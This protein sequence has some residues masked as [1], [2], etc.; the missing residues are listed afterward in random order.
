MFKEKIL[1]QVSIILQSVESIVSQ[2]STYS[3]SENCQCQENFWWDD[4]QEAV[5]NFEFDRVSEI[6]FSTKSETEV[7][8]S[9]FLTAPLVP[10]YTE[11]TSPYMESALVAAISH[12][13]EDTAMPL[14]VSPVPVPGPVTEEEED[15]S[16]AERVSRR[17]RHA[18]QLED[19]HH[20]LAS[21]D[22]VTTAAANVSPSVS[23]SSSCRDEESNNNII[24]DN[25]NITTTGAMCKYVSNVLSCMQYVAPAGKFD[26][27]K[28]RRKKKKLRKKAEKKALHPDLLSIWKN[29]DS[30]FPASSVPCVPDPSPY[31]TVDWS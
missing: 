9:D 16:V 28:S 22:L 6:S 31:P 21:P 8:V 17:R 18:P 11:M 2:M 25:N 10:A 7:S 19:D 12:E 14:S 23:P 26:V 15:I 27:A 13:L 1:S 20:D 4:Q 30:L 29:A 5:N 3:E 24:G